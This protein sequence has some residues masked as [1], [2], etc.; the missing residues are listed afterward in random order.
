MSHLPVSPPTPPAAK[1]RSWMEGDLGD[2]KGA[3][4]RVRGERRQAGPH[5]P[6]TIRLWLPLT[7]LLVLF[8]PLIFLALGVAVFLPRPLGVNPATLILGLGRMLMS[9]SGTEVDV[10]SPAANVRIKIL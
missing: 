3:A 6:R 1:P 8:S 2:W 5:R 9:L 10:D 4:R 7:V